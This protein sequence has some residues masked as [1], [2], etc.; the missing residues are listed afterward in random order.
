MEQKITLNDAIKQ[1][2]SMLSNIQV[3]AGL[4]RQIGIPLDS[5]IGSLR[6]I[7]SAVESAQEEGEKKDV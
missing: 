6:E 2:I 7:V 5:A 3:P 4:L 1:V